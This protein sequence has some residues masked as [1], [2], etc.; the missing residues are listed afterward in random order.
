MLLGTELPVEQLY[1]ERVINL[2]LM[3]VLSWLTLGRREYIEGG[4]L[5][6]RRLHERSVG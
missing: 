1:S 5:V 2:G 4:F 3:A 6:G